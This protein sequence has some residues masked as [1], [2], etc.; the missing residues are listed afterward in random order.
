VRML[1]NIA[2]DRHLRSMFRS[3]THMMRPVVSA[4]ELTLEVFVAVFDSVFR[5][6][7]SGLDHARILP[8]ASDVKEPFSF[9]IRSY[10]LDYKT[11]T[12][13]TLQTGV[14]WSRENSSAFYFD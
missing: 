11:M 6:G 1:T 12:N 4:K 2:S 5:K 8:R 3:L 7:S 13:E 9:A 10:R 14:E